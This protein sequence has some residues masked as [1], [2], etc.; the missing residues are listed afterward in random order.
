MSFISFY[1]KLLIER[2]LNSWILLIELPVHRGLVFGEPSLATEHS[3]NASGHALIQSLN[4]LRLE[5][6][7]FVLYSLPELI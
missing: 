6:L 1:S 2:L 4:E 7:P 3:L 5:I